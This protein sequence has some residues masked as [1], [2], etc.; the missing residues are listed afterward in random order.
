MT[1]RYPGRA[2]LWADGSPVPAGLG[3]ALLGGLEPGFEI[4]HGQF[5]W[6]AAESLTMTFRL[7]ITRHRAKPEIWEVR[8]TYPAKEA[9]AARAG[10]TPAERE[11]FTMM[12][13][14]HIAEWWATGRSSV[15][16]ARRIK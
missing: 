10:A 16:A 1:H 5:A 13:R 11:W 2:M 6:D 4:Q 15:T 8:L 7:A 12:V 14:T 9:T 3:E